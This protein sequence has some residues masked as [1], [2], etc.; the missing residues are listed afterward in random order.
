MFEDFFYFLC[1]EIGENPQR[2]G[3]KNTPQRL[4]DSYFELL[5]GYH[6]DPKS[7]FLSTFCEIPY[8]EMIIVRD[9]DFFSLCEHHLLPFFGHISI[10]YI[11]REKIAGIGDF[12]KLVEVFARRLQTQENLTY[13]I[14]ESIMEELNPKGAMLVCKATHLCI[15][16]RGREKKNSTLLTSAVR[17]VFK[18]DSKTRAEFL[19]H[20]KK[21]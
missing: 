1:Q 3:L 16:M 15:S 11:P 21:D 7:I 20:L 9:I 10:G 12:A 18:E 14:I 2:E 19:E 6:Q 4:R 8:N 17:G 5:S 13:Q